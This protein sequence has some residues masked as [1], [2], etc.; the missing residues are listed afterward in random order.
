MRLFIIPVILVALLIQTPVPALGNGSQEA[1]AQEE[2][3]QKAANQAAGKIADT[4]A[5]RFPDAD[6][7]V[8]YQQGQVWLEGE[9]GSQEQKKKIV[10]LVSNIPS[11]AVEGVNDG[12]QVVAS[13]APANSTPA[14]VARPAASVLTAPVPLPANR[15][16]PV[17]A[18]NTR[19]EQVPQAPPAPPAGAV[20]APYPQQQYTAAYGL[21]PGQQPAV[22]GYFAPNSYN[23]PMPMGQQ[24]QPAPQYAQQH[25]PAYHGSPGPLPGRYNQPNLPNHAWP[26]Y[27]NYP[28]YAQVSYPRMY[29]P[30]AWP[31]IG[32][33][34][35]YPQVPLGW[36]KVTL[37]HHN[38]GWWL[39]FDDGTP[40]GPFSGLFRQSTQYTY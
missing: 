15:P 34:Y 4:I 24:G 40:S 9:A 36:R 25:Q 37:E 30:K 31:Y 11:V 20:M 13:K 10:E 12:I 21:N 39:D 5:A 14:P 26:A 16:A 33:Y 19:Q 2:E 6:I 27:A 23:T 3:A 38:G 17:V 28:N 29:S 32:P 7:G 35:P 8:W 1:I 22:S 18:M